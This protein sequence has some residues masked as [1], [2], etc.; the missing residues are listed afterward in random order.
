MEVRHR[1]GSPRIIE[2]Y[3]TPIFDEAGRVVAIESINRDVTELRR[4]DEELRSAHDRIRRDLEAAARVQ[5]A[6]LP[7]SSPAPPG[8]HLAWRYRPCDELAGDAIG[9]VPIGD[10]AVAL[11]VLDV[12]GHGVPASLLSVSLARSLS[13]AQG[14]SS[15]L[16]RQPAELASRLNR[17]YPMASNGGHYATL[18]Y[19][20]LEAGGTAFRHTT[21]GHPGPVRVRPDGETARF[22]EPA[23]PLGMFDEADYEEAT[24]ELAPGDRLYLYS[25]GIYE[26]RDPKGE[27]FGR[28]RFEA[29]LVAARGLPLDA[30]IDAVL[31]AV[32]AWSGRERLLDDVAVLAVEREGSASPPTGA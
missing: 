2:A 18:V 3:D 20:I 28:D 17:V 9:I 12:S 16:R 21:A 5:Q 26:E 27:E 10:G 4:A 22:D 15:P 25:D 14:A 24:I 13:P 29:A 23:L 8:I 6:L 32:R 7:G 19:G 11:Y 1:D 31:D 30:S